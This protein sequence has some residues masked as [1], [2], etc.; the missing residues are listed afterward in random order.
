MTHSLAVRLLCEIL[1]AHRKPMDEIDVFDF[2]ALSIMFYAENQ[3]SLLSPATH[4]GC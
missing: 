3:L 1:W 4:W 2:D